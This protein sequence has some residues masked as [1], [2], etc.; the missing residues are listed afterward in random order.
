MTGTRRLF[1]GVLLLSI[2]LYQTLPASAQGVGA[3]GGSVLDASG[4]VLPGAAV[5]L[6]SSQGTVGGSQETV[7]DSRGA[8]QFLRL[9]PGTY[10]VR[11][12]LQGFRSVEQR[13]IVV[14]ADTT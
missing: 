5:T 14:N 13:N 8:Y 9:V 10:S 1:G 12:Q 7:S 3:I 2:S 11:A 4:A 6:I